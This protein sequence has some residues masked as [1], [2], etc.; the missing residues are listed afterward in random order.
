[1]IKISPRL[2]Y[3]F[4]LFFSIGLVAFSLY[5]QFHQGLEPCPLCLVQR[6]LVILLG[7][8][9]GIGIFFTP[10]Q[11]LARWTYAGIITLIALIGAASTLRKIWLE[12]LPSEKI[13]P[14]GPGLQ[15]MLD[16]L[17]FHQTLKVLLMGSGD[18]SKM[19]WQFL[20][21]AL[22]GWTLLAFLVFI[23]L[24]LWQIIRYS[25]LRGGP[26]MQVRGKL[27]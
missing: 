21:I 14:C 22:S 5:L 10:A 9:C 4:G 17:P 7:L 2:I 25:S 19:E 6:G 13:P 8:L 11:R 3:S 1:M 20:G 18:C 27:R 15:Y 24:G 12:Q 23:G 26:R 16:H